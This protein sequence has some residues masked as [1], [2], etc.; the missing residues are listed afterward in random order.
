MRVITGIAKKKPLLTI[1]DVSL[2]PTIGRIKEAMFS[3]IQLKIKNSKVLDLFSGSG[4]LGIEALS[5]GAKNCTFVDSCEKAHKI[6]LQNLKSTKL[7]KKSKVLLTDAIKFLENNKEKYDIIFLDP[8]YKT[9]LI[10][11]HLYGGSVSVAGLLN[12]GDIREQFH[13]DKNDVMILPNEMYNS[14]GKDLQGEKM[15][16]LERFYGAKIILA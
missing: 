12:H 2:R 4:Q 16:E 3:I 6:E 11:N 1:N 13:P 10:E 14:D 5:R 7:Q 15:E 9:N 8:P